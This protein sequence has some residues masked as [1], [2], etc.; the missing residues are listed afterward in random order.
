M[1]P[2]PPAGG[3]VVLPSDGEVLLCFDAINPIMLERTY[4]CN[5]LRVLMRYRRGASAQLG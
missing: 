4:T 5:K 1:S 3:D 2:L